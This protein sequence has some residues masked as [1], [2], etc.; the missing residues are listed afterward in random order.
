MGLGVAVAGA[1]ALSSAS[2]HAQEQPGDLTSP[3][4]EMPLRGATVMEPM[5]VHVRNTATGEVALLVGTQ[6]LVYR[7]H[8]LVARVVQAARQAGAV[9][10]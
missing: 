6:E 2:V 8:A 4:A 9:E 3:P 10:G 1:A 7:D 5:V